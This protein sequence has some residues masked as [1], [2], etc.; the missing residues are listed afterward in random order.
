M[1]TDT[2]TATTPA[3]ALDAT[4]LPAGMR[5]GPVHL[6]VTDLDRSIRFYEDSIGLRVQHRAGDTV[7]LGTGSEPALVLVEEP[8]AT[9]AGRHTGLYHVA[10]LYP[11]RLEL[12]RVTRRLAELRTPVEGA[13]DHH[14]H[15]ALYLPDPDGNGLELAADR[16]R[17]QW[18]K[19]GE[20]NWNGRPDPLDV[21]ALLELVA[22]EPVQERAG[23]GL[24][25]GHLHM[26]VRD[27]DEAVAFYRDVL[28][29]DEMMRIPTA[30]F[31]AAGGYH[32]HLGLNT[33][34][35]EGIP[36]APATA[37]G[38]RHWTIELP[39]E[40]DVATVAARASAAGARSEQRADGLLLTDP[41]GI[42]VLLRAAGGAAADGPA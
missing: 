41:S 37:V 11:S 36:P 9:R 28:G 18:P 13:S 31:M 5:L 12:A 2:H 32:H 26:H 10:L 24:V 39:T 7:T 4:R 16:P 23:D 27:V 33:W 3:Q 38:L 42:P 29:L 17:D 21:H 30:A 14:T 22:D 25:V 6:T 19:Q 35:G 40:A 34:R 1:M 8:S 20:L 15:E